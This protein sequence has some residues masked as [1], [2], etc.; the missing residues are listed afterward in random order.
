MAVI[1]CMDSGADIVKRR[2]LSLDM[3][4]GDGL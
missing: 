4:R 1:V 2:L 3:L